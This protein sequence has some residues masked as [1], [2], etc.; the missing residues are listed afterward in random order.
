MEIYLQRDWTTRRSFDNSASNAIH[1]ILERKT[2]TQEVL[3]PE[4]ETRGALPPICTV[5]PNEEAQLSLSLS[6]L[7]L[8]DTALHVPVY[9]CSVPFHF[10]AR[11]VFTIGSC[12]LLFK[13]RN[14][15][16]P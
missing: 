16:D 12:R 4:E 3:A 1:K 5:L 11:D 6:S 10:C 8:P 14:Q 15:E 2:H 13:E 7:V 9:W